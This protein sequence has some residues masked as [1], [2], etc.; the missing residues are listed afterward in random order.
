M[1][2]NNGLIAFLRIWVN[3]GNIGNIAANRIFNMEINGSIT[4][5]IS[6]GGGNILPAGIFSDVGPFE[7]AGDLLG[8][9]VVDGEVR[10]SLEVAG[11]IGT[12][13]YPIYIAVRDGIQ[14]IEAGEINATFLNNLGNGPVPVIASI[15]TTTANGGSGEFNGLIY[16][17]KFESFFGQSPEFEFDG[18]MNGDIWIGESLDSGA[19]ISVATSGLK[20]QIIIGTDVASGTADWAFS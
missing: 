2:P 1:G 18:N 5:N 14:R 8:D 12:D 17:E 16:A 4:G 9:L 3:G 7:I 20:G 13:L 6:I 11:K 10:H 15:A 19:S